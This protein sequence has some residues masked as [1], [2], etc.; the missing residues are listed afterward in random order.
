MLFFLL[1]SK[2]FTHT[3]KKG[4]L[5]IKYMN[6]DM[7]FVDQ[8]HSLHTNKVETKC[9]KCFAHSILTLP[10]LLHQ[11]QGAVKVAMSTKDSLR[12]KPVFFR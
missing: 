8:Q 1:H 12:A 6:N 3:D 4:I 10:L 9:L 11:S 7:V 5:I 2:V